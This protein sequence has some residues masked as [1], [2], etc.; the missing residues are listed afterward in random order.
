MIKCLGYQADFISPRIAKMRKTDP[1]LNQY[2]IKIEYNINEKICQD[3]E[4]LLNG[5]K[6]EINKENID[7]LFAIF[8]DLGNEEFT[9]FF[10][11]HDEITSDNVFLL[12]TDKS[13]KGENIDSLISYAAKNFF[14]LDLPQNAKLEILEEIFSNKDFCILSEDSLFDY[15]SSLLTRDFGYYIPLLRFIHTEALSDEK[16]NAFSSLVDKIEDHEL[17]AS[18][19]P[20]LKRRFIYPLRNPFYNPR[21]WRQASISCLY[22]GDPFDGIFNYLT[23]VF[24]GNI[25]ELGVIHIEC[26]SFFSDKIKLKSIL[27][28]DG[29]WGTL[30]RKKPQWINFGFKPG[31]VAITGYTIRTHGHEIWS[32]SHLRSWI[33]LGSNDEINWDIIDEQNDVIDF[34]GTY[35]AT[36]TFQ[37]KETVFYS[38]IRL[39]R[40]SKTWGENYYLALNRFE[41]FGY[42]IDPKENP[43]DDSKSSIDASSDL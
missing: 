12:I 26:S 30:N 33:L 2:M 40:T 7:S 39:Q 6:I 16:A 18:L 38:T 42:I 21:Y 24:N 8:C 41:L 34:K 29:D 5:N 28:D 31:K 20:V 11:K 35:H 19:W 32:K 15:I 37:T 14:Q 9:S 3:F 43:D 25:K 36:K 4:M 22:K 10:A 27:E 17:L 13:I 1:T 23:K